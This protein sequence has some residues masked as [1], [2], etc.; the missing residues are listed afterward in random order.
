MTK[1]YLSITSSPL[2]S[3]MTFLIFLAAYRFLHCNM[4]L[5]WTGSYFQQPDRFA[6]QNWRFFESKTF[7]MIR[8]SDSLCWDK[9]RELRCGSI[10]TRD[11]RLVETGMRS[12]SFRSLR[13]WNTDTSNLLTFPHFSRWQQTVHR[14]LFNLPDISL[15]DWRAPILPFRGCREDRKNDPPSVRI[16]RRDFGK[17]ISNWPTAY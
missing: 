16:S 5:V 14:D 15:V 3:G 9:V 10:F 13:L 17:P 12:S 11:S 4:V 2:L 7:A 6:F 1:L 8:K